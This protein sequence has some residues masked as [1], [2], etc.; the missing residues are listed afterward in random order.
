MHIG[1]AVG[2]INNSIPI[3]I[4]IVI[5]TIVK[6]ANIY[7]SF[8]LPTVNKNSKSNRGDTGIAETQ[9]KIVKK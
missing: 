5:K 4:T 6:N 9:Y 2:R 3:E 1:H 7:F 8:F